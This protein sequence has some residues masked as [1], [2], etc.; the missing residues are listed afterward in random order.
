LDSAVCSGF[1][2]KN[3]NS[4]ILYSKARSH[5]CCFILVRLDNRSDALNVLYTMFMLKFDVLLLVICLFKVYI[6]FNQDII[7]S[8]HYQQQSLSIHVS[9]AI[10]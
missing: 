1:G 4:H 3:I 2:F 6:S 5:I 10:I 8:R 7:C 9:R